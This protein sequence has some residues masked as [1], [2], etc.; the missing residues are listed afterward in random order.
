MKRSRITFTSEEQDLMDDLFI[1]KGLILRKMARLIGSAALKGREQSLSLDAFLGHGH[2]QED[3]ERMSALF[4]EIPKII[5]WWDF[6]DVWLHV[7]FR[8]K[9][10]SLVRKFALQEEERESDGTG[11]AYGGAM[12][13]LK[14]AFGGEGDVWWFWGH[15]YE[16]FDFGESISYLDEAFKRDRWW[17]RFDCPKVGGL[18]RAVTAVPDDRGMIDIS[19]HVSG[20]DEA[21]RKVSWGACLIRVSRSAFANRSQWLRWISAAVEAGQSHWEQVKENREGEE[22]K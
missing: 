18:E 19:Q 1:R 6:G 11:E 21:G 9:A 15:G 10:M 8:P 16:N 17:M 5:E 13:A 20:T 14:R 7:L 12:L 3:Y 2:G 22:G 4:A